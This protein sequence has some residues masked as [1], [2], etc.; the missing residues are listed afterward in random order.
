MD[1]IMGGCHRFLSLMELATCVTWAIAQQDLGSATSFAQ[2]EIFIGEQGH[3]T[4][5]MSKAD[6]KDP[7]ISPSANKCPFRCRL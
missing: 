7:S 6:I 3:R 4:L 1:A 5:T 2:S